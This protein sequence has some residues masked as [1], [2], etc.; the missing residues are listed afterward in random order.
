MIH[1]L[2]LHRSGRHRR[3]VGFTLVELLVVVAIIGMLIALLLPAVQA[4]REA[5]N[6]ASCSNNMRQIGLA[7]HNY[8]DANQEALPPICIY[9]DRPT[10]HMM[11]WPFMEATALHNLATETGLF[12]RA[13][14]GRPVLTGDVPG[15]NVEERRANLAAEPWRAVKSNNWW[16][17][18]MLTVA[19]QR[20]LGAVG[21]YRCPSSNGSQAIT[22]GQGDPQGPLTDYVALVAKVE[23]LEGADG[24]R[25]SWNWWHS[26]ML[27]RTDRSGAGD[28]RRHMNTFVGPFRLPSIAFHPTL[29]ARI[30][31]GEQPEFS[32]AWNQGLIGWELNDTLGRWQ[33]GTSN[34]LLFA[35]KHIPAHAL[36]PTRSEHTK[37]NGGFQL[38]HE[39]NNAHN[40]ARV[41]SGDASMFARAP[42]DPNTAQPTTVQ[43]QEREGRETIGSSHPGVVNFLLGDASV[44]GISKT[45]DPLLIW[46]LTHV[47]DGVP[48][49][50]P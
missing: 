43:P 10:I 40:I 6:R 31:N 33:D 34:Q 35:E 36:R 41:V 46:R 4:A 1:Q 50:L 9:A 37:W 19:E 12:N 47:S 29:Q 15:D 22:H 20:G 5:A 13:D 26:Y 23:H 2:T 49:S 28:R 44:R 7:V 32:D 39:G 38:T 27:P 3:L 48:V 11:I 30:A 17:H 42:N 45:T 8:I 18:N 21:S 24:D 14:P 25:W 16:F